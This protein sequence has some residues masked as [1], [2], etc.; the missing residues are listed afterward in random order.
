ME[1]NHDSGRNKFVY[2]TGVDVSNT[3]IISFI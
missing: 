1:R 3:K 2:Y